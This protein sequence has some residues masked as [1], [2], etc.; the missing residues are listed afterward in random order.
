MVLME[1]MLVLAELMEMTVMMERMEMTTQILRHLIQPVEVEAATRT[2]RI[3]LLPAM[4]SS[5][6]FLFVRLLLVAAVGI[7]MIVWALPN[8]QPLRLL[9][10]ARMKR[11]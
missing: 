6:A 7:T 9:H 3:H 4:R 11:R 5:T 10:A 1:R 8:Q 2:P